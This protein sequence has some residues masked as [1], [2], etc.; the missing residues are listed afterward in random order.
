MSDFVN[1]GICLSDIPKEKMKKAENGKLYVNLS[2]ARRKEVDQY[3][4]THTVFVSQTKEERDA[5]ADRSFVGSG[6]EFIFQN[7]P[8]TPESVSDMP[9]VEDYEK[10]PWE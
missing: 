9:V 10:L 4:Q 2:V 3:G 8:V 6:K 7:T 5:K 1:I